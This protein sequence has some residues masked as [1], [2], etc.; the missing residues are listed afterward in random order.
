MCRSCG[1]F[2]AAKDEHG[3]PVPV[4]NECPYCGGTTFKHHETG[5]LVRTDE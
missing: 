3:Q 2:I 5:M 4:S 1:Q